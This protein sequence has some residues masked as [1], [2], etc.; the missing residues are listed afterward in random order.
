M[1]LVRVNRQFAALAG[2]LNFDRRLASYLAASA[3]IASVAASEAK[4]VVVSN[5]QVQ[6]FGINGDVNIDFNSDG[7]TDFQI[8]HDRI[9]VN[10]VDLDFLQLDKN[11]VSSPANPYAINFLATFP[12]NDTEANGDHGYIA[13][14]EGDRGFYPNALLAG[15]E[16]GPLQNFDF[17]EGDNFQGQNKIIRANRLIDEDMTQ[18]DAANP[19]PPAGKMPIV[20]GGTP[21]WIGLSGQTRYL[22]VRID[23]ND[24]GELGLNDPPTNLWYGWIGVASPTRPTQPVR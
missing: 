10:G 16:I 12:L 1:T 21:G 4:A 23:L 7:Q 5:S 19:T 20:P 6:P 11:D 15:A 9:N 18:V 8:D 2:Q 3:S 17:Q 22:G 13:G 14:G 24:A